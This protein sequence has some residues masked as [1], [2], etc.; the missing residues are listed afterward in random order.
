[1]TGDV[2]EWDNAEVA[3][4][5]RP[6]WRVDGEIV[7]LSIP[8]EDDMV[9]Q[10]TKLFGFLILL[11]VMFAGAYAVGAQVGPIVVSHGLGSGGSMHMGG[12]ASGAGRGSATGPRR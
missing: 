2:M 7:R 11:A 10:T 1:M 4:A 8:R 6:Q 3:G 9:S 12:T 5:V